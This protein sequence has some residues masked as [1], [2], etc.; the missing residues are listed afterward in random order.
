M[1][2]EGQGAQGG[3]DDPAESGDE[4]AV[5][6][7]QVVVLPVAPPQRQAQYENQYSGNQQGEK[8]PLGVY[9]RTDQGQGQ[10]K[11]R[12]Q[13][14]RAEDMEY[15]KQVHGISLL[16]FFGKQRSA[17]THIPGV[18]KKQNN[19]GK[20]CF[21]DTFIRVPLLSAIQKLQFGPSSLAGA[22]ST[23]CRTMNPKTHNLLEKAVP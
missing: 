7:T 14:Q 19:C 4:Y 15:G 21:V 8:I 20:Q 1:D 10:G 2:D 3:N 17:A 12:D 22:D 9:Q 13:E 23:M 18:C 5:F 6:D 16:V 11:A